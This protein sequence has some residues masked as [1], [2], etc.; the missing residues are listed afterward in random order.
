MLTPVFMPKRFETHFFVVEAP[1]HQV[2]AHDGEEAVDSVWLSAEEA[3]GQQQRGLRKIIFPTLSQLERL[4]RSRSVGEALQ[5]AGD[6]PIVT[7]LPWI[8][9]DDEGDAWLCLP[10][11]AGYAVTRASLDNIA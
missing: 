10:E 9:T 4:G 8:E 11:D 3:L 7:V 2:A 5:R 6:A 1:A